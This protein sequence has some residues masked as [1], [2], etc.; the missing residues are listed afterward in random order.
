[1]I[2]YKVWSIFIGIIAG[3]LIIWRILSLIENKRKNVHNYKKIIKEFYKKQKNDYHPEYIW[4][5]AI[6][7]LRN[8]NPWLSLIKCKKIVW[9]VYIR[10]RNKEKWVNRFSKIFNFIGYLFY[11]GIMNLKFWIPKYQFISW[12]REYE[13]I[14]EMDPIEAG[15]LFSKL[16]DF[17]SQ[18]SPEDYV[19]ENLPL[20][21]QYLNFLDHKEGYLSSIKYYWIPKKNKESIERFTFKSFLKICNIK[22]K[23]TDYEPPERKWISGYDDTYIH[24]KD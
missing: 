4:L 16:K 7:F 8:M 5:E 22:L 3:T 19:I 13:P 15:N 10:M 23:W 17:I 9:P 2:V 24:T 21:G 1:M 14:K 18:L 6:K 20:I 12:K 11:E